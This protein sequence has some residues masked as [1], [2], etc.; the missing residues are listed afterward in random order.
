[1]FCILHNISEM[2][3]ELMQSGNLSRPWETIQTLLTENEESVPDFRG[4]GQ[5]V[6]VFEHLAQI[7]LQTVLPRKVWL[8]TSDTNTLSDLEELRVS[9]ELAEDTGPA[10]KTPAEK[11]PVFTPH[12]GFDFAKFS[13]ETV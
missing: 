11:T 4:I 5:D 3:A 10:K 8:S 6:E 13:K 12:S 1:M 9:R 2:G 7:C